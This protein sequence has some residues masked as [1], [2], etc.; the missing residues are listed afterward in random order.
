MIIVNG[1][2]KHGG[3]LLMRV[4]ALM[5]YDHY[6]ANVVRF[7][8]HEDTFYGVT[9]RRSWTG[10][11]QTDVGGIAPTEKQFVRGYVS[12]SEGSPIEHRIVT[13]S[14]DP[15]NAAL[16][17]LHSWM[18]Q[19]YKWGRTS[20]DLVRLL[21]DCG[22]PIGEKGTFVDFCRGYLGWFPER[23][24]WLED[25]LDDDGGSLRKVADL[26]GGS[27]VD[28]SFVRTHAFGG[29]GKGT[30]GPR[31]EVL[32]KRDSSWSGKHKW[33]KWQNHPL[34]NDAVEAAWRETGGPVL[35]EEI[36]D[37]RNR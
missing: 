5:G 14:R 28:L 32:I 23:G 10:P 13:V 20:G 2:P 26:I 37:L 12:F 8:P 22:R 29:N 16:S 31:N 36:A 34:W 6:I 18:G 25:L 33:T 17:W 9:N 35:I 15:R 30:L 19:K 27:D 4:V 21:T 3:Y 11:W 24:V 7:W 1:A